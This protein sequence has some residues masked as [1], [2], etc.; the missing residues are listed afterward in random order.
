MSSF[1]SCWAVLE[2]LPTKLSFSSCNFVN[3]TKQHRHVRTRTAHAR[4][5]THAKLQP[6]LHKTTCMQCQHA[7]FNGLQFRYACTTS[8][9]PSFQVHVCLFIWTFVEHLTPR[10]V[11]SASWRQ[12][13]RYSLLPSHHMWLWMSDCSLTQR[14]LNIHQSGCRACNCYMTGATWNVLLFLD[15]TVHHRK[16]GLFSLICALVPV[17]PPFLPSASDSLG[18][19]STTYTCCQQLLSII[20]QHIPAVNSYCE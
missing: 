8:A 14:I 7:V 13:Q 9:S 5:H 15:L 4:T 20:Q 18:N 19:N 1:C 3:C 2:C 17:E 10:R 12:L 6:L 11:L 16:I